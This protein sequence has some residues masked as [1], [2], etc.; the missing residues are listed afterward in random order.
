MS[1]ATDATPV[2][3]KP[4]KIRVL[5][6]LVKFEHS[7]FALPYAFIGA[8]YGAALVGRMGGAGGGWPTPA[9]ILWIAVAMVGARAFAFVVNRAV[10]KEIDARNPRTAGRAIPAGLIKA[11]ELWLF[12]AFML[13]AYLHAVFRLAPITRWL[14]PIPLAAFL[15]YPYMK[16]FTPLCHYWLGLCLG[17]APVAGWVAVGAP[18][19]MPGPW[20][21]GAA[22]L[23]WTAGFDIIYAT[24]DI[25]CDVR[26]KIH[27]MPAD[28]GIPA[29]LMQ[30]RVAHVATV[31]LLGVGGI[32]I[33]A[34]A[35]WFVGVG[36]AAALLWYENSIV[37]VD[38]LSRVNAAF[39]TVNGVIAVIVLVGAL[40]DRLLA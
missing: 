13:G 37:K 31:L 33:G 30:T 3:V 1:T 8:L 34:G 40:A 10:D 35:F 28:I 9:A 15:A 29:A 26:D 14:W 18:I 23:L 11:W 20:I 27:S 16:R 12:A 5:L 19:G 25:E 17:L 38:D 24:Q 22:V 32:L 6:E 36:V 21:I 4:G 39:F 7:I 2:P